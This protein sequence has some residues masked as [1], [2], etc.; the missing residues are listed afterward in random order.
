MIKRI[1]ALFTLT[2]LVLSPILPIVYSI[3]E[4]QYNKEIS[5]YEERIEVLTEQ[6]IE[7]CEE[8]KLLQDELESCYNMMDENRVNY[9]SNLVT[10]QDSVSDL[11]KHNFELISSLE[12]EGIHTTYYKFTESEFDLLCRCAQAEAGYHNFKSQIYV[13]NVIMN[14]VYSPKFPNT[15][16]DVIYQHSGEFYQFSVVKNGMVDVEATEDTINNIKD[17]IIFNRFDLP[18]HVLYFHATGV[19]SSY[20]TYIECEGTTFFIKEE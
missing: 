17:A 16:H 2:F 12:E 15:I 4:T 3:G 13:A 14:R 8:I 1:V 9:D 19:K 10:L 11:Q 5:Y 20:N 6:N 7:M 18:L